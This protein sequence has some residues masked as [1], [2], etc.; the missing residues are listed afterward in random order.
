MYT[1]LIVEDSPFHID[2]LVASLEKEYNLIIAIDAEKALNLLQI[3]IPDVIILDC[4]LPGMDGFQFLKILQADKN[5][6][7][8]PVI[9]TTGLD[10]TDNQLKGFSLGAV[11]Y[12]TKPFNTDI[13]KKRVDIQLEL[14]NHRKHLESLVSARTKELEHT[15]DTVVQAVSYLAESRDNTTGIH[16]FNTQRYCHILASEVATTHPDLL[17]PCEVSLLAQASALHDIGKVAVPDSIL[18][19]NESLTAEEMAEMKEHTIQGAQA[20]QTT[21]EMMGKNT[22]LEKA[23]EIAL[24]H[25]EKYDGSGYP[26]NLKGADIPISGAIVAIVDVYDALV[27]KRPY[28]EAYSHEEAVEIITHGDGRTRPSHF[29]PKVLECFLRVRPQFKEISEENKVL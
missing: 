4:I 27:S 26:S 11:D 7:E 14:A 19:K 29:H 10:Q 25:H 21:M 15:R 6:K 8:I 12:I 18:L 22:F 20:I 1:I 3:E 9:F 5:L 13:V 28:K 24:S 17:D 2:L 23:Y 16:I